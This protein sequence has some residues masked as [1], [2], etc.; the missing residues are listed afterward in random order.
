MDELSTHH[1][2]LSA[3]HERLTYDY[4]KRKQELEALI[5]AHEDLMRENSLLNQQLKD[6]PEVFEPPCLKCLEQNNA[7]SSMNANPSIKENGSVS[8]ENARLK[9]LLQTGMFKSLKGHQTICDVLKKSILHKNPRKEGI[10]F[11]ETE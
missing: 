6:K 5:E 11:G 7:E 10:G 4:L 1:D 8:D 3:D 2:F 9:Y